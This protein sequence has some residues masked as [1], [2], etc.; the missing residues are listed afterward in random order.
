MGMKPPLS[1]C[2]GKQQLAARIPGMIP[3]HR[4]YCEPFY[5][6]AA[7]FFAREPFPVEVINDANGRSSIFT[8]MANRR[9]GGLYR[10]LRDSLT[11]G[12]D[13]MLQ[14][15]VDHR[16]PGYTGDVLLP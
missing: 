12:T 8:K 14:R 13:R 16:E 3:E 2:G 10:R 7:I 9:A 11:A 1:Y 4:I 5:G 15:P 6:G